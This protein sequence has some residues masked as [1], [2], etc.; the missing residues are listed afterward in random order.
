MIVQW[1]LKGLALR[2]DAEADA[3][4]SGQEGLLANWWRSVGEVTP[5]EIRQKLTDRNAD[6]H[7]NHFSDVD[8]V[9]KAPFSAHS[10]FISLTAGT[11]ERDSFT[12]TNHVHRALQVAL[13]F[14]TDFGRRP[15]AY[16]YTCWTLVGP[17]RAVEVE[18]VAEEVRDLNTY[19]RYSEYQTEGEI[20]AKVIVPD[21]QVLKYERWDRDVATGRF[22]R[23]GSKTNPRFTPPTK[24]SN[25]RE[26]I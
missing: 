16:V 12:H 20:L 22:M 4:I 11:V 18:S 26:L 15:T 6:R 10:P 21:N 1:C 2:D 7:V 8:P 23:N 24:L 13:W 19:R 17:R 3:I 9:T 5:A 14:G 25:V